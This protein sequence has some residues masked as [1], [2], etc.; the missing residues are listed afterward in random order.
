MPERHPVVRQLYVSA[1]VLAFAASFAPLWASESP[2][3]TYSTMNLW[4][5]VAL[6]GGGA[7]ALGVLLIL[8]MVG[9]A[10]RGAASVSRS[11]GVP[12][13]MLAIGALALVMLVT[14][15]G[16]GDAGLGAGS[17][18]LL[19]TTILLVVTALVDALMTPRQDA[20]LVDDV[21]VRL[22]RG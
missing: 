1:A 5:A 6:D 22:P 17:G 19:G 8:A 10:V 20:P 15:P 2:G 13:A 7:A 21:P 9:T 11:F 4:T 14:R 3:D 12:V 18:L 16:S